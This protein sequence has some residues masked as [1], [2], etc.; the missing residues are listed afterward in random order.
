MRDMQIRVLTV[1]SLL[2][3]AL[4]FYLLRSP[5]ILLQL[6]EEETLL[7][8]LMYLIW[9]TPCTKERFYPPNV[10]MFLFRQNRRNIEKKWKSQKYLVRDGI[11]QITLQT[12][13]KYS[14]FWLRCSMV[15]FTVMF[16]FRRLSSN[17]WCGRRENRCES[18]QTDFVA[19]RLK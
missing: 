6:F 12:V 5:K 13:P 14:F 8:R 15:G 19:V 16:I 3:G 7:F 18:G 1:G 11:K 2:F 17:V 9:N 10:A 4:K